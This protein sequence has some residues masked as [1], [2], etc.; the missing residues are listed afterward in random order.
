MALSASRAEAQKAYKKAKKKRR[1]IKKAEK[2]Q[3]MEQIR[4]NNQLP[5]SSSSST[6]EKEQHNPT[7]ATPGTKWHR[8]GKEDGCK[9]A[10]DRPVDEDLV[11]SL[12]EKRTKA[13]AEKKYNVSD[14]IAATL[15]EME[16]VYDD[17]MK[18]WHTRLLSTVAKKA[19]MEL[20]AK[21]QRQNE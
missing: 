12:L 21:K 2:K 10:V 9:K 7:K 19:R 11:N 20:Q 3:E 4:R 5:S 6:G 13:K 14:E 18:E 16:I 17:A 15:V 1:R 8:V